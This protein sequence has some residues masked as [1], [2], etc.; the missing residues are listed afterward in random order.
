ML[1]PYGIFSCSLRV[2][3]GATQKGYK[4]EF[5]TE[6]WERYVSVG[7]KMEGCAA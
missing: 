6:A 5:F 3:D 4:A 7:S 1:R 2:S